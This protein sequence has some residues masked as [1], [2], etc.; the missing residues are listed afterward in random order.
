MSKFLIT[1]R[2]I[3]TLVVDRRICPFVISGRHYPL[4][5]RR[6]EQLKINLT[7]GRKADTSACSDMLEADRT[8]LR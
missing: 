4:I 5:Q 8:T 7:D 2:A 3:V 6:G 1:K